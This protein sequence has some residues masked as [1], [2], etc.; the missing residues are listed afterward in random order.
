M[1]TYIRG[2]K[3][4]SNFLPIPQYVIEQKRKKTVTLKLL[5]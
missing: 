4:L 2:E 5:S 3:L 1:E